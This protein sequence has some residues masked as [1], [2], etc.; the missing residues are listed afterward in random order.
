MTTALVTLWGQTVGEVTLDQGQTIARFRYSPEFLGSG[1]QVAPLM[2]PL[3]EQ[4]YEFHDLNPATFRGLPGLLSDSLPD[5]FGTALIDRWLAMQDFGPEGLDAVGRLRLIGSRGMGALSFSPYLRR[6]GVQSGPFDA[7]AFADLCSES[8]APRQRSTNWI[9]HAESL[10]AFEDLLCVGMVAGGARAKAVVAWDPENNVIRPIDRWT[11]AGPGHW[12]LKF[13][14]VYRNKDKEQDDPTGYCVIEYVYYQ[15]ACRAGIEMSPCMLFEDQSRRHF[16]TRCFDRLDDDTRL[17]MQSL[18]AMAHFDFND[19]DAYSYQQA[20]TTMHR[21]GLPHA[22]LEAQFR[23]MLF[24]VV[25][26]NQDDHVK[27]IAFLMDQK[28][29][30]GTKTDPGCGGESDPPGWAESLVQICG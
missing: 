5:K 11:V 18:C 9:S 15:M 24:N 28:C 14:G 1:L 30:R 19:P 12:L 27:N 16:L 22:S 8:A 21:L 13:D 7:R 29:R 6:W 10:K 26:R 25:A 4:V 17:H 23:R 2:M 3:S 20:F